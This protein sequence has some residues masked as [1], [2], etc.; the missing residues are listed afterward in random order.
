MIARLRWWLADRLRPNVW[1][2]TAAQ[3]GVLLEQL[4]EASALAEQAGGKLERVERLADEL[5]GERDHQHARAMAAEFV[6][7][8]IARGGRFR[9]EADPRKVAREFLGDKLP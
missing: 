2:S 6:L 3:H 7:A 9:G 8:S 5:R 1:P 4:K